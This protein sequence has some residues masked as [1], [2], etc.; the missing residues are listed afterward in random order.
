[1]FMEDFDKNEIQR[2]IDLGERK[3]KT[4]EVKLLYRLYV[5]YLPKGSDSIC[6]CKSKKYFTFAAKWLEIE[7]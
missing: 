6:M 5:S 1:M 7:K 3:A 4:W 2:I